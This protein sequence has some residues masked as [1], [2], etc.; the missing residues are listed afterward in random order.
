[1]RQQLIT[2]TTILLLITITSKKLICILFNHF[3][4]L[5]LNYVSMNNGYVYVAR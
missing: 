4:G 5:P 1:M 2:T 3:N